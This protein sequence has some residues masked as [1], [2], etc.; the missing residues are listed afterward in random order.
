MREVHEKSSQSSSPS[1]LSL[2]F[3]S[4]PG[5]S[6]ETLTDQSWP[7]MILDTLPIFYLLWNLDWLHSLFFL[8]ALLF[9][10]APN[11]PSM[12]IR[13]GSNTSCQRK[14]KSKASTVQVG[15]TSPPMASNI[16]TASSKGPGGN[17]LFLPA[18]VIDHQKGGSN[19]RYQGREW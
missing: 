6:R 12:I 18:T 16:V 4:L 15:L 17:L 5:K 9:F 13:G 8:Q 10:W 1:S 14:K 19:A 3:F 11:I 2:H 7:S